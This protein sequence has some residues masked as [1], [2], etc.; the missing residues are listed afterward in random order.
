MKKVESK[1]EVRRLCSR[2]LSPRGG[3][4]DSAAGGR[5]IRAFLLCVPSII[6]LVQIFNLHR[7]ILGR[8]KLD[9][10]RCKRCNNIV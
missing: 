1:I 10:T 2:S 5:I 8:C 7:H 3:L 4:N 9:K 6:R